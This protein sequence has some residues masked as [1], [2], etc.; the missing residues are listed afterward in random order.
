[1]SKQ[2]LSDVSTGKAIWHLVLILSF[3]AAFFVGMYQGIKYHDG[4]ALAW[5]VFFMVSTNHEMDKYE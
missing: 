1:V 4:Y 5:G 3:M 2:K